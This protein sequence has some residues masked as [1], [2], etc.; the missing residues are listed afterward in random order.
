MWLISLISNSITNNRVS[1]ASTAFSA[2]S[3]I[4]YIY[5][6][7]SSQYYHQLLLAPSSLLYSSTQLPSGKWVAMQFP[8]AQLTRKYLYI[9]EDAEYGAQRLN[10]LLQ[11]HLTTDLFPLQ[12]P[13][14]LVE[15]SCAKYPPA[16]AFSLRILFF[17]LLRFYFSFPSRLRP[18]KVQ[19][20]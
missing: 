1:T 15:L 13:F 2:L 17:H 8:F 20:T 19:V 16:L 7:C 10:I 11:C 3:R 9:P 4:S 18:R 6:T 12:S 5:Y 14:A